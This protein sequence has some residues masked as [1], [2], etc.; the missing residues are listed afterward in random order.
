GAPAAHVVRTNVAVARTRGGVVRVGAARG[1]IAAVGGADIPVVAVRRRPPDARPATAGVVRRAGVAVAAGGG[2]VRVGA[3]RGRIAAVGGADIPVVAVRRRPPDARPATARV[4]GRAG[5]AVAAWGAVVRMGAD[6]PAAHVVRA[7][8]AIARA[9]GGVV[10]VGAARGRIAAVGGADIPVVAGGGVVRMGAGAPAA[11]VVRT[12]VA[13]ARTR[14]GVVRVDASCPRRRAA[15]LADIP[16]VAVRRRPPDA[17]PAT[18]GVVRRAGVAVAARGGV[19]RVGAARRRI[20]AVG[21]ADVVPRS[22]GGGARVGAGRG[23]V[24]A[25][26]GAEI[27]C[28]RV[29]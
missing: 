7:A 21:G 22:V 1:R 8:I 3:A 20:A 27:G 19:V 13:V 14:G 17:R 15:D 9:R 4:V 25:E 26:R 2:V 16:V 5:V 18:A 28:C 24:A 12:Y 11:H 10:R 23:R 6:T 29:G